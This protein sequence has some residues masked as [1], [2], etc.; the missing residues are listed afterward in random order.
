MLEQML[1]F[2]MNIPNIGEV[3]KYSKT[4]VFTVVLQL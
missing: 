2:F 3:S 4:T 1:E